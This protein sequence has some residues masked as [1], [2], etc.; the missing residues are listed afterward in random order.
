MRLPGIPWQAALNSGPQKK[1]KTIKL[2]MKKKHKKKKDAAK[3][4]AKEARY[5]I[6]LTLLGVFILEFFFLCMVSC[7]VRQN[8]IRYFRRDR[9]ASKISIIAA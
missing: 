4:A 7:S 5:G 1:Y 9:K 6:Y 2:F 3:D 8:R